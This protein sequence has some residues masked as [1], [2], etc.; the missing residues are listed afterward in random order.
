[1]PIWRFFGNLNLSQAI[2]I[3]FLTIFLR[4]NDKYQILLTNIIGCW[5]NS[6]LK[7]FNEYSS[8]ILVEKL[9]RFYY[10]SYFYYN[11]S[12]LGYVKFN[13]RKNSM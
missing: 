4:A 8:N 11:V 9:D 13:E 6:L 5:I 3:L 2:G 1:M 12:L 7:M 10:L